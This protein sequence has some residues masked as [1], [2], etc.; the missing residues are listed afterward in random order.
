M[1][2][3]VRIVPGSGS[4]RITEV[5]SYTGREPS[6]LWMT[7]GPDSGQDRAA[8]QDAQALDSKSQRPIPW[9]LDNP[10]KFP[11]LRMGQK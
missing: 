2:Q 8:M 7:Q 1:L 10:L 9:C 6:E 5:M 4:P 11:W 3:E